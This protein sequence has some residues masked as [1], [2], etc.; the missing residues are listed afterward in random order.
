MFNFSFNKY[1]IPQIQPDYFRF[2]LIPNQMII[3]NQFIYFLLNNALNVILFLNSF[4]KTLSSKS[5]L[6]SFDV[7]T[8]RLFLF[9][10]K[11]IFS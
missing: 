7:A 11:H 4:T 2:M 8:R 10:S 3:N 5:R 9:I 6:K 1:K